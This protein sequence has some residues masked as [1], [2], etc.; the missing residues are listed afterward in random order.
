L[1]HRRGVRALRVDRLPP[2][3]DARRLLALSA[4]RRTRP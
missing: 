3:R 2:P 1:R 4:S